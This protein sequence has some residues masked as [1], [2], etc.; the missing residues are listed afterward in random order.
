[1]KKAGT[2]N[3]G[4]FSQVVEKEYILSDLV[5]NFMTLSK[6]DSDAIRVILLEQVFPIANKLNKDEQAKNLMPFVIE[7]GLDKS[8]RVRLAFAKNF[9]KIAEIFGAELIEQGIIQS[10][11]KL[12][13]DV[14][15]DVRTV[16]VKSVANLTAT[17]SPEKLCEHV[18]PAL[19]K[20]PTDNS[21]NV[22]SALAEIMSHLPS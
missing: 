13:A 20:L 9:G 11:A 4:E 18:M 2:R 19:A 16:A 15:A 22:K 21:Q 10:F 6:D 1:M 7:S 3:L 8:W 17:L 14:E 12:L 5:P